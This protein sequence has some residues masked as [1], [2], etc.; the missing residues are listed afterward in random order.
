MI[1]E[2][3]QTPTTLVQARE[4][5]DES[6]GCLIDFNDHEQLAQSAIR[7]IGD[8]QLRSQM[9]TCAIE[10]TRSSIWENVAIAHMGIIS[11]I[12]AEDKPLLP[13]LP[14]LYLDHIDRMTTEF[15]MLQFS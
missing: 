15:G 2:I 1:I 12:F 8:P 4:M 7:L 6:C 5:L 3:N 9:S 14:A 10:K 13:N 11:S